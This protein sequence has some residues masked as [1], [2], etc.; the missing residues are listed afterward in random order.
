M[1]AKLD[2]IADEMLTIHQKLTRLKTHWQMQRNDV[3]S[4]CCC[5]ILAFTIKREQI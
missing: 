5:G 3:I 1:N 2:N 4:K